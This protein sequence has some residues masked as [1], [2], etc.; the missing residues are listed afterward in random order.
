MF[1]QP[2]YNDNLP[3]VSLLQAVI[4]AAM[5]GKSPFVMP[6]NKRDEADVAKRAFAVSC[7]DHLTLYNAYLR[8]KIYVAEC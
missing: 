4:A 6:I 1:V 3:V 5:T 8:Y 7:S 2:L